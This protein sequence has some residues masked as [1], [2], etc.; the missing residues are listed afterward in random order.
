MK[1]FKFRLEK[2]LEYRLSIKGE[3]KRVLLEANQK[4]QAVEAE[5]DRL[6]GELMRYEFSGGEVLTIG[7]LELRASYRER[8]KSMFSEALAL[9]AV[10]EEE[11]KSALEAY[12]ASAKDANVL[13]ALKKRRFEEY[14]ERI[15]KAEEQSLD[16]TAV[17]RAGRVLLRKAGEA[18]EQSSKASAESVPGG[19]Q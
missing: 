15:E 6:L 16:E 3:M 17:Q 10:R 11:V 13:E 19:E 14:R 4:L 2:V 5:R 1:K 8:T 9:A 7:E 12:I 18:R